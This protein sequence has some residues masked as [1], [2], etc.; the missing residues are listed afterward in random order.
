MPLRATKIA[1][2]SQA[3]NPAAFA[4]TDELFLCFQIHLQLPAFNL[5]CVNCNPSRAILCG[6][7]LI[8]IGVLPCVNLQLIYLKQ[9]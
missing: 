3:Q 9:L 8:I 4:E 2:L 7:Y 1:D 6:I 5:S